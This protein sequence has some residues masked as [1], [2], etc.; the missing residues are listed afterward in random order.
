MNR[1]LPNVIFGLSAIIGLL[2]FTFPLISQQLV[3][4]NPL[5]REAPAG[6]VNSTLLTMILLLVCLTVLL[7]ELH[8]QAVNAKVVATLGILVAVTSVLRLL[9]TAIPGPGGFSPIFVPIILAG[10]VYGPRF[11]FLMG[12]L[13][14]V[15]SA[16]VTGGIGPW[17]PYQMIAAGWI[18]LTAG[19]LP[20]MENKRLEMSMLVGFAFVWGILFGFIL[21]L[22]FWPYIDGANQISESFRETISRYGVFYVTSSLAWDLVRAVGNSLLILAI[23][24]PAVRALDRFRHRLQFEFT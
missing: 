2:A 12:S 11:G 4:L 5:N 8:G 23:G 15:T 7:L 6:P 3:A 16:L 1:T 24:L 14:L 19:L 17:L 9:E 10:Y 21:N 18:G 20:R 13:S 22:Y